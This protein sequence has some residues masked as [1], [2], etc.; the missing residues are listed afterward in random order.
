ME[1]FS[2]RIK[3]IVKFFYK[4]NATLFM[5]LNKISRSQYYRVLQNKSEFNQRQLKSI[6]TRDP[7]IDLNWLLTGKS[8]HTN[9][10][11]ILKSSIV[12]LSKEI[13]RKNE[14]INLLK[15][16]SKFDKPSKKREFYENYYNYPINWPK[17]T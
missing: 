16:L 10:I 2:T 9:Y 13:D 7:Q 5:A 14:T 17:E 4:N 12:S 8:I 15:S 6:I 1:H 3:Y 11:E